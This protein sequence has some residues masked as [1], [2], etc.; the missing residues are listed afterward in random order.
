MLELGKLHLQLALKGAGAIREDA[1]NQF[2]AGHHP[3]FQ[4]LLQIALLGRGKIAVGQ[5]QVGLQRRHDL[6]QFLHLA[7]AYQRSGMQ[8]PRSGK[9]RP[10]RF[11]A[12]GT[13]EFAEFGGI[14]VPVIALP[15]MQQDR[16]PPGLKSLEEQILLWRQPA[17]PNRGRGLGLCLDLPG[18]GLGP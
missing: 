8:R 11:H 16:S 4:G 10:G 15:N 18:P 5:H 7:G 12:G 14:A 13:G 17:T 1:Q 6:A 9:Q 3:A 2:R